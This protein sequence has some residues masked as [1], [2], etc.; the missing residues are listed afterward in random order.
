MAY[1]E[2]NVMQRPRSVRALVV[3]ALLAG[4]GVGSVVATTAESATAATSASC[5][6]MN[7]KLSPDTRA[8][9]VVKRMTLAQKISELYGRGDFTHYGAANEIP[10]IPSLCIPEQVF[11]DAGAG[12]GDAKL[13]AKKLSCFISRVE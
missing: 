9:M 1:A 3:A 8:A 7:P 11:N 10:A 13:L 5:P 4:A 12:L 2:G 6:W